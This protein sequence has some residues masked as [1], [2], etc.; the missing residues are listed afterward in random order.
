M[1]EA[2]AM[3]RATRFLIV[4]ILLVGTLLLMPPPAM[5]ASPDILEVSPPKQLTA[6]PQFDRN[7]SFVRAIDGTWWVFF[8]RGRGDPTAPGY[9]PDADYYDVRYVKSDDNGDTWTEGLLPATPAGH[10]VM[11]AVAPAAFQDGIGQFW[12]FYAANGV[13]AYYFTSIDNGISWSVATPAV[14]D[15]KVGNHLD[16]LVAAD[17]KF[18]IYYQGDPGAAIH[19]RSFD[20]LTWSARTKVGD[21]LTYTGTPRALQ[22]SGTGDFHVA[23]IAGGPLSLHVAT[24]PD[25]GVSWTSSAVLNT[26]DADYDPV[27]VKHDSTW[28]L[29]FAPYN[30][31]DDH[32]WLMTTSSPDLTSWTTPVH[33]TSGSYRATE[34]WDFWPEA[35]M[36]DGGLKLFYA[37]M[38][39]GINRGDADIFMFHADWDLSREHYEAIQ[40]A[41]DAASGGDIINA[42]SG[43]YVE[44]MRITKSLTL[45]GPNAGIDPNTGSRVAEAVIVPAVNNTTDGVIAQ[46]R[47]NDVTIDGF[48]FDGDNP[49]L[50]GGILLNGVD[51]NAYSGLENKT[52]V[53]N[54]ALR[55]NIVKNLVRGAIFSDLNSGDSGSSGNYLTNNKFD[56][57]PSTSPSGQGISL[58]DSFYGQ[59]SDNVMTRVHIGIQTSN[60]RVTGSPALISGNQIQSYRLGI[61]HGLQHYSP[62][63]FT[64]QDNDLTTVPG[65]AGNVGLWLTQIRDAVDVFVI[66]NNVSGAHSGIQAWNLPT[67][68][69]IT[70]TGGTLNGNQYGVWL[71]NYS[72][73]PE[74]PGPGEPSELTLSGV[75]IQNSSGAGTRVTDDPGLGT[76]TVALT[77]R[78]GTA[79]SGCAI[80]ALVEKDRASLDVRACTLSGNTTAVDIDSGPTRISRSYITGNVD[81]V[82]V[83]DGT[84]LVKFSDLSGNT[85]WA[86]NNLA[87]PLVNASSNWWGSNTPLGVRAQV[88]TKVDYTPWL[89]TGTDTRPGTVGFQGDLSELHVDDDSPQTGLSAYIE[90]GINM[91]S[92]STVYVSPGAYTE[93][94]TFPGSF[95]KDNLTIFGDPLSRPVISGGAEVAMNGDITGL[96]WR[97]LYLKGDGGSDK[98]I[99]CTNSGANNNFTMDNCVV[100][101]ENDSGRHGLAGNNFGLDFTLTG[102]EFKN[103]LGWSVMDIN[104][105]FGA[106]DG[107]DLPLQT[108]TF[109]DNY[110]HHCEGTVGLRG[111]ATSKTSELN[112]YGNTFEYIAPGSELAALVVNHAQQANVY[113]NIVQHVSLGTG[114]RGDAIQFRLNN[115]VDAH[116]NIIT[117]NYAGIYF[118]GGTFATSLSSAGIHGNVLCGNSDFDLEAH[119]DHTGTADAEGNWWGSNS[120]AAGQIQGPVDYDP[121]ITWSIGA[122][123]S[124]APNTGSSTITVTY[125]HASGY[126]VPDG[127]VITWTVS[128]IGS[129]DPSTSVT[130]NGVA[131]TAL[132]GDGSLGTSTVTAHDRCASLPVVVEF[133]EPPPTPTPT[134]TPTATPTPTPTPPVET[135]ITIQKGSLGDSEDTYIYEYEPDTKYY[136]IS[137]FRVGYSHSLEHGKHNGLLHFD[138]SPIPPGSSI[139]DA[140]L[141]LYSDGWSGPTADVTMGT[142][143]VLRNN[144]ISQ[145]TWNEAMSGTG[146][147]LPGC[148][149]TG[150]DRVPGPESSVDVDGVDRWYSWGLTDTVQSWVNGTL[151]NNGLL[152][153]A[154][155]G[156]GFFAFSSADGG[157]VGRRP[158][159]VVTYLAPGPQ[160]PPANETVTP[161]SGG[162]GTG[163]T[164]VFTTTWSDPN[165]WWDLKQCW[166]HVGASPSRAGNVTLL[167]N[168]QSDKLWILDDTGTA[169]LG[170]FAPGSANTLENGQAQVFCDQTSTQGSGTTLQVRWA[171]SFKPGFT[172]AKKTGLKCKDVSGAKSTAQWKGTW[173]I[174]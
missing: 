68:Q 8:A 126:T 130:S 99:N 140:Q 12:V 16:A 135:T 113:G 110:I 85:G 102:N 77:M 114:G 46:L 162:A 103:L 123:P 94:L 108:V 160:A 51:A 57:M 92:G 104:F 64:I 13:G 15:N 105:D 151:T 117:D 165:G 73:Y 112:A 58:A 32:Q 167:Y 159:L 87:T 17:G 164:T 109:A 23:Y 106:D 43:T 173:N 67:T 31:G 54:V 142:Y 50:G 33:V 80:G 119:T 111:D 137:T 93:T 156:S 25:N 144:T 131:T 146:W 10:G 88:S 168:A 21:P 118:P 56:N 42:G 81:G 22:D 129:V 120:P 2:R 125:T 61:W 152:L 143:A 3:K 30:A 157:L 161:S 134:S 82:L 86:V 79:I 166:F 136:W 115:A 145:A 155:S 154:D 69:G 124:P 14:L 44:R 70:V 153:R 84:A 40:P 26:A 1:K 29:F 4:W 9:D 89:H 36:A 107:A 35:A 98:V 66:N 138:L 141:Q 60:F 148:N 150:T 27:L 158:K 83:R 45:N 132:I 71:Y 47:A 39:D 127:H 101:G 38:K 20:G 34:W 11:G 172:G 52:L 59:L 74:S 76:D 116:D 91:V 28:R 97:N 121:W 133:A 72:S 78:H 49:D 96:T 48:T 62:S 171:I 18:W 139:A 163:V 174:F 63:A 41:I 147:G 122:N 149:H 19:A 37:S 6:S 100:D 75:T 95:D 7:P 55:N 90:E 169:W 24:S 65:A 170:G 53:Q 128:G 5:A